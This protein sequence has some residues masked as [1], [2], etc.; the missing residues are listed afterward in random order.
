MGVQAPAYVWRHTGCSAVSRSSRGTLTGRGGGGSGDG[1]GGGVMG[2]GGGGG[3][4]GEGGGPAVGGSCWGPCLADSQG[5]HHHR[6]LE[7]QSASAS[8]DGD[9]FMGTASFCPPPSCAR[10][11]AMLT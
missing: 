1:A 5:V 10:T 3:G 2:Q 11:S 7:R 9:A 6:R 8:R 4:E